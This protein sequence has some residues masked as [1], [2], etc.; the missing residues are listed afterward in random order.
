[1]KKQL[2]QDE[3]YL[4][5]PIKAILGYHYVDLFRTDDQNYYFNAN[6]I[7]MM[8][9]D[10]ELG[11]SYVI[12]EKDLTEKLSCNDINL[13]MEKINGRKGNSSYSIRRLCP[14]FFSSPSRLNQPPVNADGDFLPVR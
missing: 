3:I 1:M 4:F 10:T 2:L 9:S 6:R 13:S 8:N 7:T 11:Y 14:A 5:Q 12:S